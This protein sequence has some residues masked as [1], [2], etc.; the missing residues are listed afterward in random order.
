MKTPLRSICENRVCAVYETEGDMKFLCSSGK[1][2]AILFDS[3]VS[4]F[5]VIT[6]KFLSLLSNFS[7]AKR[8]RFKIESRKNWENNGLQF[9]S[10]DS[11]KKQRAIPQEFSFYLASVSNYCLATWNTIKLNFVSFTCSPATLVPACSHW[12]FF[13]ER[14][15]RPYLAHLLKHMASLHIADVIR[16]E[17]SKC[18]FVGEVHRF[19]NPRP[20]ETHYDKRL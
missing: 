11:N 19:L 7:W 14:V 3:F 8:L 13:S 17:P 18:Q 20:V 6:V 5:I 2:I 15:H 10:C 4:R 1:D 12:F 9:L 16:T